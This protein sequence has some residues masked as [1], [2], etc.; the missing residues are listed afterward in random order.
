MEE[1][2]HKGDLISNEDREGL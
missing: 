1:F 2:M